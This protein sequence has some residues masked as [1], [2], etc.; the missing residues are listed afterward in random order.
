MRVHSNVD[1]NK[2]NDYLKTAGVNFI[3]I[4]KVSHSLARFNSFKICVQSCDYLK[5]LNDPFWSQCGAKCMPWN[6]KG[7]LNSVTL[8]GNNGIS[9]ANNDR[10]EWVSLF[11]NNFN[12]GC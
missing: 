10:W 11:R 5:V 4:E 1:I 3:K 2:V 6:D 9:N 8:S 12:Y 7:I